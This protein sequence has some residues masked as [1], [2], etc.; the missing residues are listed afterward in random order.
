MLAHFQTCSVLSLASMNIVISF[1][2]FPIFLFF[3]FSCFAVLL[4]AISN[5]YFY[6]SPSIGNINSNMQI[7][8]FISTPIGLFS[9]Y[10]TVYPPVV[11]QFN[12]NG[13]KFPGSNGTI[14]W[15]HVNNIRKSR[16]SVG[17]RSSEQ[18]T[19]SSRIH[20]E[21]ISISFREPIQLIPKTLRGSH[22]R[23]VS[24][25]EYVFST[26]LSRRSTE[27]ILAE[28]NKHVA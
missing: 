3:V 24:K 28:M 10:K 1:P 5:P 22:G 2:R 9:L 18:S 7:V 11:I 12:S 15:V 17:L 14:S 21:A 20:N 27:D 6:S 4:A 13:I 23:I 26:E 16:M 25:N 19:G 8:L